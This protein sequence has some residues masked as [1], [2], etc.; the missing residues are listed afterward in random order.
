MD[1]H[2]PQTAAAALAQMEKVQQRNKALYR[3]PFTPERTLSIHREHARRS[4]LPQHNFIAAVQPNNT[5]YY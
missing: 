3:F 2:H 1:V 4:F 5:H